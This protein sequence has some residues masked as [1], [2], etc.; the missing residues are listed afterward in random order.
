MLKSEALDKI[1][2]IADKLGLTVD[3]ESSNLFANSFHYDFVLRSNQYVLSAELCSNSMLTDVTHVVLQ[4]QTLRTGTN[5]A[6]PESKKIN[7]SLTRNTA[8]IVNDIS[9][10]I[11]PTATKIYQAYLVEKQK[12]DKHTAESLIIKDYIKSLTL[13]KGFSVK[14]FNTV[15]LTIELVKSK[16]ELLSIEFLSSSFACIAVT[17]KLAP[18]ATLHDS[19]V[20][21]IH[22]LNYSSSCFTL[23]YQYANSANVINLIDNFLRIVAE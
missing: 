9:K 2:S 6:Q 5:Y 16:N 17:T 4:A 7:V 21:S 14:T 8:H 1:T 22:D 18:F 23:K 12:H 15:P 3:L 19:N 20:M 13:P 10:R 11:A